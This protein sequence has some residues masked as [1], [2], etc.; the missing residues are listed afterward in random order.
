MAAPV[1]NLSAFSSAELDAL[2][3]AAKAAYL[4]KITG[5]VQQGSSSAQSYSLQLMTVDDLSRLINGITE[6]LG[7]D[8]VTTRVTPNFNPSARCPD[9]STFGV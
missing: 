4:Q 1:L 3:V 2:L 8:N 6:Q 9:S 5:T 7:L